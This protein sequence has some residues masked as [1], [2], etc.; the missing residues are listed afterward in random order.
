MQRGREKYKKCINTV[1]QHHQKSF[2]VI[3]PTHLCFWEK[4]WDLERVRRRGMME[5]HI[6]QYTPLIVHHVTYRWRSRSR[7]YRPSHKKRKRSISPMS[8]R[9]AQ[10][11]LGTV[12]VKPR[13]VFK[14]FMAVPLIPHNLKKKGNKCEK[15]GIKEG[16]NG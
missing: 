15:N 10:L 4:K 16:G 12:L 14:I 7:S 1:M 2:W 3:P 11:W 13:G 9:S 8:S 5:I 6:I